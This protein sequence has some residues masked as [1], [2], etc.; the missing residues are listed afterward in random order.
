MA[1]V[2]IDTSRI[3]D[4]SSLHDVLVE[5]FG[6]PDSYG[7]NM[8]SWIEYMIGIDQ[9]GTCLSALRIRPGEILALE[10]MDASDF[11]LRCE[12][13][14]DAVVECSAYVNHYRLQRELLPVLALAYTRS[15]S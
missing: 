11:A 10:L 5:V 8:N 1:K 15:R 13:L 9:P 2:S 3:V 12:D 4:W 14:Y 7:R 6:L